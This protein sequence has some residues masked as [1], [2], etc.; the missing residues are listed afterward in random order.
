KSRHGRS[1]WAM[2][3]ADKNTIVNGAAPS[4]GN[5]EQRRLY[6][7]VAA[8]NTFLPGS[9]GAI[10]LQRQDRSSAYNSMQLTAS[11]RYS[12]NFTVSGGYTLSKVVGDFAGA[13]ANGGG[14]L[15]PYNQFQDPA[16]V[17]GPLDQDHRHRLT[18]SWVWDLPGAKM[19]GPAKWVIAGWQWT[20]V[21]Q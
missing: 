20:G 15:I 11:K 21:M 7:L 18:A 14:E 12:H 2:N 4:T 19:Q 17:R 5:T 10:T 13:S 8:D 3:Y 9:L 16:L 6:A 1:S